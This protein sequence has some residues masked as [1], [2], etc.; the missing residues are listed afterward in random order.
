MSQTRFINFGDTVLANR[1]NEISTSIVEP[2]VLFGGE[3]SVFDLETL[4]IAPVSVMLPTLLLKEDAPQNIILPL[5]SDPEDYTV[6]YEHINQNIQGG[7]P[8]NLLLLSGIFAFGDLPNTVILGWIRYPGGSV[9]LNTSFFIEAPKL[10]VSNSGSF[11]SNILIPPFLPKIQ[12]NDEFPSPGS[13]TYTDQFDTIT[14]KAYIELTNN[15]VS[16]QTIEFYFPFTVLNEAPT[17]IVAE[18]SADLGAAVTITL[19]AEDGTTFSPDDNTISNT[20][21]AFEFRELPIVNLDTSK[22]SQNRPYYVS[23]SVQLNPTRQ[24]R[25]SAIGTNTNF[26]PF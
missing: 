11:A 9:P 2:G 13:I 19:V 6:V 24:A 18:V 17:R 23:A 15:A 26:L 8:A 22:F 4:S 1:I 25:I 7:A 12:L 5:T 14:K 10:R 20:S 21:G 3:F 16:I